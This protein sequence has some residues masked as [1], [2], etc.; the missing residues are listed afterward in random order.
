MIADDKCIDCGKYL[1][2]YDREKLCQSCF[3][4]CLLLIFCLS[5]NEALCVVQPMCSSCSKKHK[6]YIAKIV[7]FGC[8]CS[9]CHD[10]YKKEN[11]SNFLK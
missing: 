3:G 6:A 7:K 11:E 5:F 1:H 9:S 4:V 10:S 2:W 8:V